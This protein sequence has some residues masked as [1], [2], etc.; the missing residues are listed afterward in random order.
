MP[1]GGTI[2]LHARHDQNLEALVLKVIDTGIGIPTDL[3]QKI[4]EPFFSTKEIGSG[5]GLGL[6]IA[7]GIIEAHG[8]AIQ[9][10]SEPNQGTTIILTLPLK[11]PSGTQQPHADPPPNR[12]NP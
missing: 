1:S 5:T 10:E 6:S 7:Q 11:Q 3:Y 12:F 4:F 8:G 2:T 9:I